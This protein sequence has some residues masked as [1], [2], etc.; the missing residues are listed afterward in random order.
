MTIAP[1][2]IVLMTAPEKVSAVIAMATSAAMPRWMNAA[3]VPVATREWKP[4]TVNTQPG[5]AMVTAM[6]K[7]TRPGVSTMAAIAAMALTDPG[8]NLWLLALFALFVA[9]CSASQ[10]IV[11]D[12][13]RVE[14]LEEEKIGAGASTYV[15]G[16]RVGVVIS[17]T[18]ALNMVGGL[19]WN[20]VYLIMAAL[21]T[22]G[23]ITILA[24][25]EPLHVVSEESAARERRVSAYLACRPELTRRRAAILAW[26]YGAAVSPFVDFMMR[27]CWLV[28]LLFVVFYKLGDSMAGVMTGYFL[29]E[30]GFSDAEIGNIG[31]TVGTV[32]TLMGFL[33]GGWMMA[34]LGLLWS[35]WICGGAQMLSNLVFAVQA[36]V[37]YD[38]GMLAIAF[39]IENLAGGMG[40]AAFVAYLSGL[41]NLTYTATQ[42]A[43]LSAVASVG[44]TLL[45]APAGRLAEVLDWS[46]FFIVTTAAAL[47]GL[48]FLLW[49]TMAHRKRGQSPR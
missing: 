18:G 14:L 24:S 9:I 16:Y 22:I 25:R 41:C 7:T 31:K 30:L 27:P 26:L 49:I 36:Q 35:L 42:Y 38:T 40:T 12:A 48:A 15:F 33:I 11:I 28:M 5:L 21:V 37:G 2:A 4:V 10:D 39:A 44:R 6:L 23:L 8:T 43:L 13:Y 3:P 34:K 46:P 47:P 1:V 29:V 45:A 17:T 32:S 20:A 19:G